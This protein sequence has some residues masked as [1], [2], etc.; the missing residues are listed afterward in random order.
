MYEIEVNFLQS[1][2]VFL[3]SLSHFFKNLLLYGKHEHLSLRKPA[4]FNV[5]LIIFCS[6]VFLR[7]KEVYF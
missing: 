7:S 4:S 2:W 3:T 5:F 1:L 6:A